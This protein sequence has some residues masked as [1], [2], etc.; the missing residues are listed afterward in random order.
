MLL[1]YTAATFVSALL[2]FMVQPMAG[3]ML[4]PLLGGTPAVWTTSMLFFQTVLLAGYAYAHVLSRL[5]GARLQVIGHVVLLA[6][7]GLLLPIGLPANWSPAADASPAAWT[8][9]SL[10]LMVGGPFFILSAAGPL[11]QR[12]FSRTDHPHARD[13][14][15]LYAAS[16]A[17]SMLALL[18]YPTLIEP[19]LGVRSQAWIWAG[20]YG[21]LVVLFIFAGVRMLGR[22]S[23][24][25][26]AE[27]EMPRSRPAPDWRRRVRWVAL[28]AAASSLML[29]TTS[30]LTL[31]VA[32]VPMLW[33][34][35][36]AIYLLTFIIAFSRGGPR[37]G[38]VAGWLMPVAA[39]ATAAG[40][41]HD[42]RDPIGW[43]FALHLATLALGAMQ[44][45]GRLA[46][47]RPEP[48]D[49]TEFYLLLALGGML[50][51]V[52]NAL[53]APVVFSSLLEYPAAI[54]AVLL[55]RVRRPK[56]ES[57]AASEPTK[58]SR[59]AARVNGMLDVLMPA[60]IAGLFILMA[61]QPG[62]IRPVS[63]AVADLWLRWGLSWSP[64]SWST[65]LAWLIPALL[66]LTLAGHRRRLA[67]CL[68]IVLL[69][70]T[71]KVNWSKHILHVDRTFFGVL[72]VFESESTPR[73][74][75]LWHGRI[76]HGRQFVLEPESREPLTYYSREGPL[77][78]VFAALQARPGGQQIAAVGLG[79]G[80]LLAYG[81][82]EDRFS[83]YEIDPGMVRIARDPDLF[84]Y[85]ADSPAEKQLILGDARLTLSHAADGSYDAIIIDAFSSDA[86]PVHLITREAIEMFTRK[87]RPDGILAVHITNRYLNLEPVLERLAAELNLEARVRD[88]SLLPAERR[89]RE[90]WTSTWVVLARR[91]ES[92][93][94]LGPIAAKANWRVLQS[95]EGLRTWTDDYSDLLSV[96]I[97]H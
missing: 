82:A 47:D 65:L 66:T 75:T 88:D 80:T 53:V 93:R 60:T 83:L 45:H 63:D 23:A 26:Q 64:A 58:A 19:R 72:R 85:Y 38:R 48:R 32:A 97:W 3:K 55:L 54:V 30:Y 92:V 49:L 17:G 68:G 69:A 11:L 27:A 5:R 1:L 6:A 71:I 81:R 35:P 18:A 59:L 70:P 91:D 86:I 52:F 87:L 61:Q 62:R 57:V 43:I 78:D 39:T 24:S 90:H 73:L 28:A 51:G 20:A 56:G 12:W 50:G 89:E 9:W 13:P 31:D 8:L 95:R 74:H 25:D 40:L 10:L 44:C 33:I 46:E 14:Y 29:G 7:A 79:A 76:M 34:L 16:N 22:I 2:L 36:L 96:F 21:L 42:W 37:V 77:G 84:S 4:L 15:F 67:V 94:A 41:L